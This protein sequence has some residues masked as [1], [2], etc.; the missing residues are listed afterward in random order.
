MKRLLAYLFLVLGL[1]LVFSIN[2]NAKCKLDDPK[3]DYN[4]LD[5]LLKGNKCTNDELISGIKIATKHENGIV[6]SVSEGYSLFPK[7]QNLVVQKAK[8]YCS[9]INKKTKYAGSYN[10]Q[11]KFNCIGQSTQIAKA[12]PTQKEI[13]ENEKIIVV[14][15]TNPD[16]RKIIR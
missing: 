15:R 16:Y 12:E 7:Y 8:K 9:S 14:C 6:L 13:S 3:L 4:S 1:G 5:K 10:K 2:A 11:V